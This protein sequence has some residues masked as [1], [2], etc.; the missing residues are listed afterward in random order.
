MAAAGKRAGVQSDGGDAC[1]QTE[2]KIDG[3]AKME[4]WRAAKRGCKAL[5]ARP[6]DRGEYAWGGLPS[7]GV[8]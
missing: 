4:V 5:K 1:T 8:Q 2:R 6:D 3:E 7:W